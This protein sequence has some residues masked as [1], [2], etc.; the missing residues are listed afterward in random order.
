MGEIESVLTR[1]SCSITT[2]SIAHNQR[3]THDTSQIQ[4]VPSEIC[5]NLSLIVLIQLLLYCHSLL[6]AGNV[7]VGL[8]NHIN[9]HENISLDIVGLMIIFSRRRLL[10]HSRA[11]KG[12]LL[13]FFSQMN[14]MLTGS[15][16]NQLLNHHLDFNPPCLWGQLPS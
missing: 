2:G 1:S 3:I 11:W 16:Q 12:V 13:G 15:V 14:H 5:Y 4:P 10:H 9:S 6:A 7:I 8:L